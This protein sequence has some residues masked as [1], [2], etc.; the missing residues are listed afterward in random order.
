[1]R[2]KKSI[3]SPLPTW[4]HLISSSSFISSLLAILPFFSAWWLANSLEVTSMWALNSVTV[5]EVIRLCL[6]LRSL[7]KVPKVLAVSKE[8]LV[9]FTSLGHST[10]MKNLIS[11]AW[12]PKL[13]LDLRRAIPTWRLFRVGTVTGTHILRKK[14]SLN[15]IKN[16][17]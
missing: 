4:N 3:F 6:R 9:T 17:L 12:G 8:V 15:V 1:M 5:L 11:S 14:N 10:S 13:T 7:N 2:L 16:N